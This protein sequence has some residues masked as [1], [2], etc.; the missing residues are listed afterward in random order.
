MQIIPAIDLKNGNCVRLLQG[1]PEKETVYSDAPVDIAVDFETK[2]ASLIHL[3]DL[4]GAFEGRPVNH[5]TVDRIARSVSCNLEIG[6][7]IRTAED[8]ERYLDMGIGRIILGTGIISDGTT[9]MIRKFRG[10][11][12]AGIDARDSK[13]ATHGW[14]NKT[15]IDAIDLI[16]KVIDLGIK[17][18]IY[19]DIS[20]DG[21]MTGPNFAAIENILSKYPGL[22]LIASGGITGTGDLIRLSGFSRAGLIG[23]IIGKAIYEGKIDVGEAIQSFEK[24][25]S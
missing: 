5:D 24:G 1:D 14:K 17:E 8:I 16:G 4:D 25:V 7:G 12:I 18:I 21:M 6:G 3:V 20:T 2:G 11:I 22:R 23:C 10:N 9:R 19:T 15:E 13:A